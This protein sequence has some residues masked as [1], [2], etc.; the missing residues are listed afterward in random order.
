M[1]FLKIHLSNRTK[2][3]IFFNN[4]GYAKNRSY[5]SH[6]SH[7]FYMTHMTLM[8]T[9]PYTLKNNLCLVHKKSGE[10]FSCLYDFETTTLLVDREKMSDLNEVFA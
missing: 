4:L 3:S 9:F 6:R 2:N 10:F 8:T 5:R 7:T 1:F